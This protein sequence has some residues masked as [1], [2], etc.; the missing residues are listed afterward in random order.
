VLA[1][2]DDRRLPAGSDAAR[3]AIAAYTSAPAVVAGA[4]WIADQVG[5]L[6]G[7]PVER[8]AL[9]LDLDVVDRV[10]DDERAL[11]VAVAAGDAEARAA[12][13]AMAEP[14]VVVGAGEAPDVLAAL[15]RV[16]GVPLAPLRAF[17][18]GATTVM[19]AVTGHDEYVVDGGNAVLTSWD[20]V[21][22]T[23]R[24][25]D[26]LNRDRDLLARLRAAALDAARAWPSAADGAASLAAAL[27]RVN[28]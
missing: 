3:A 20:D 13:D 27:G 16:A 11:R 1:D 28:A 5:Q 17:A 23:S 15:P 8:F 12:V 18:R 4:A 21:R 10:P 24:L 19:T 7:A 25:L 22:G 9:G 26:L 2:M 14:H 6:R